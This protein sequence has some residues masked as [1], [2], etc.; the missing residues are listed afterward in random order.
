MATDKVSIRAATIEDFNAVYPLLCELNDSRL[1]RKDWQLLFKNHWQLEGFSPGVLIQHQEE[2]VGF[3]ATIWMPNCDNDNKICNLSSWIVKKEYRSSSMLMLLKLFRDKN[4]TFTSFSSND[5]SY[6]IYQKLKFQ[7]W[8]SYARVLYPFPS[9][10]QG[11]FR[12]IDDQTQFKT[13][14]TEQEYQ[15]FLNHQSL[16]CQHILV[17]DK[18]HQY[19]YLIGVQRGKKLKLYYASD[20]IFIQD[21]ISGLRWPLMKHFGVSKLYIG[22]KIIGTIAPFLSRKKIYRHPYQIKSG[23]SKQFD[24]N[25]LTLLY[26]EL[27][28]LGM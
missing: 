9:L 6:E 22:M 2:V 7:D 3:I 15:I 10:Q 28:M 14:L 24:T 1:S 4:T 8:E 26:S 13:I 21:N 16:P 23:K 17:L 5:V 20:P 11:K 18:E 27:L 25:Q 19:C 12:I